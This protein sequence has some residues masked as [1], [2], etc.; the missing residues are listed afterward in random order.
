MYSVELNGCLI[1]QGTNRKSM[2]SF[3]R[4][5]LGEISETTDALRLWWNGIVVAG[6]EN[7]IYNSDEDD[8][9]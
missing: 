3:F 8:N 4:M 9:D 7:V 1:R 6:N 2:L 5:K